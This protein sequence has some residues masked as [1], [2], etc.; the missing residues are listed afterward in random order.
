M[1]TKKLLEAEN[2]LYHTFLTKIIEMTDAEDSDSY[3]SDDPH[4]CLEIIADS[5]RSLMTEINALENK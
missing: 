3:F 5:A 2:M 4:V 1:K